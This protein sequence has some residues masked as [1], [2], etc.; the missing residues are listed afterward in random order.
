VL[1]ELEKKKQ[2]HKGLK[3]KLVEGAPTIIE[4]EKPIMYV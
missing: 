3:M 2:E 1:K 4:E